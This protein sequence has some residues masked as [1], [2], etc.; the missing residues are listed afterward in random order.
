MVAGGARCGR[1]RAAVKTQAAV[2]SG[3][4]SP[5]PAGSK[6]GA[7]PGLRCHGPP[8]CGSGGCVLAVQIACGAARTCRRRWPVAPPP[9]RAV[10]PSGVE[11][12]GVI[13][14]AHGSGLPAESAWAQPR[15]WATGLPLLE[16]A[17]RGINKGPSEG[18]GDLRARNGRRA[19]EQRWA[20]LLVLLH[21]AVLEV[22]TS[23]PGPRS[24]PGEVIF[25]LQSEVA[26]ERNYCQLR[27]LEGWRVGPLW[28]RA[29]RTWESEVERGARLGVAS[30]GLA[31]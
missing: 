9:R 21:S 14:R 10:A 6:D 3:A 23:R 19:A 11:R 25:C 27:R 30:E 17:S 18:R 24:R 7:E 15:G 4:G 5:P 2:E 16:L 31:C 1:C 13:L 8:A 29:G 26:G 28:C 20:G 12:N 22:Q